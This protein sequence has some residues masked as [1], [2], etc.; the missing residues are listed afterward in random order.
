MQAAIDNDHEYQFVLTREHTKSYQRD[1]RKYKYT[2][3]DV[4]DTMGVDY[5]YLDWRYKRLAAIDFQCPLYD[6]FVHDQRRLMTA[7]L[8]QKI[9]ERD[10]YTCQICGKYMPSGEGIEIDHIYP[11]SKGGKTVPKNLQVL[12]SK[13]NRK[14]SNRT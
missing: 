8:R 5:G 4:S 13:C 11:V 3:T 9:M 2:V 12:C 10:H 14:K 1:Y 6:Y 7:D